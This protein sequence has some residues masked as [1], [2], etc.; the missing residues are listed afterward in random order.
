MV[1]TILLKEVVACLFE[2]LLNCLRLGDK[3]FCLSFSVHGFNDVV[4]EHFGHFMESSDVVGLCFLGRFNQTWEGTATRDSNIIT[5]I[6]LGE[7]KED[8]TDLID[9]L[10][11]SWS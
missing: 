9:V 11:K 8:L 7:S 10:G 3:A 1:N 4:A 2:D 5:S 6:E